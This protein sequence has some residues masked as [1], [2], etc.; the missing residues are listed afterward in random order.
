M[1]LISFTPLKYEK[2]SVLPNLRGVM[3]VSWFFL[4][5][6]VFLCVGNSQG[7]KQTTVPSLSSA[8]LNS[9]G[10][11]ANEST[12]LVSPDGT[13][14][15]G[16]YNV[17]ANGYAFAV[18]YANDSARTLAWMAYSTYLVG[19]N[20]SLMLTNGNLS[21]ID[22]NG[23]TAW[24]R[25]ISGPIPEM[26]LILQST[27]NLVLDPTTSPPAWESFTEYP[28]FNLLPTQNFTTGDNMMSRNSEGAYGGENYYSLRLATPSNQ[29]SLY[30][31]REGEAQDPD[32]YWQSPGSF[33]EINLD[34]AGFL[35][36]STMDNQIMAADRGV[37]P[38]R[39]LTLDP[40]GNLRLY[41]RNKNSPSSPWIKV[42]EAVLERC[43]IY[44]N[45]GE[46][47]ICKVDE[48]WKPECIC[49]PGF[50]PS[51]NRS[52]KEQEDG[53][54]LTF[55]AL[56]N[57]IFNGLNSNETPQA[58]PIQECMDFCM[59]NISCRGFVH[60][61]N[62]GRCVYQYGKLLNGYWSPG[63]QKRMYLK[64]AASVEK[65]PNPYSGTLSA[66][67]NV[68]KTLL[69]LPF[70]PKSSDHN[71]RDLAI[72]CSLFGAELFCGVL[73]FWAFLRKYSKFRDIARIFAMDLLP[74]GGPKKF[75]YAELKAATN[76]F[77]DI[78]GRGGFGPVYRG[79]LPDQ[80]QIAVKKLEGLLQG[81]QQF[82]AEVM[83]I[84]RIH[85]LN[86]VRMWGFCADGEHRLLV[87]EYIPNGSLDSHLFNTEGP[88]VLDW[89]IR[90]RIALGVARAIAYLHEECLEW[91]LHCDIK[92]ENILLDENFCPKV[93]DFGL[94]KLVEKER[95][96]NVSTIRGT[97]GYLAPE[98]FEVNPITA[99]ADV[100]SFGMVLLEIVSGRRNLMMPTSLA[101]ESSEWYFPD[102]AFD[103]VVMKEN[104]AEVVDKR[105]P[106][107]AENRV[108]LEAVA[109]M[110]RTALWCIQSRPEERPSMGKVA[111][112]LEGTVD[113][114]DP[115]KLN[116]LDGDTQP[117]YSG[118]MS[119]N[120]SSI[121]Y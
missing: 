10:L 15:A 82:W 52:C 99:K 23:G 77:S 71:T 11:R 116:D 113:I 80:R 25:K 118:M 31:V 89:N 13:F 42:W 33:P 4:V 34:E 41:S 97:R 88:N 21:V 17:T 26:N 92:P 69:S 119:F 76:N 55:V 28:T 2:V 22:D 115:P 102:W 112:M 100:Y 6:M 36:T 105:L 101:M 109:R 95:S 104:A 24:S 66:L 84:G 63:D 58:R 27:G 51:L 35:N 1:L 68:C 48:N 106:G 8:L 94:A 45:C 67:K 5:F 117:A 44:G 81:E 18:W 53:A 16:F 121:S 91:V 120:T 65:A 60:S 49:P 86:L 39:R 57:V 46:N 98:W 70:P 59:G 79:L 87:Y 19:A 74:S 32:P 62:N 114:Q 43:K 78:L 40:D 56:D 75:T 37:G 111:K 20:S 38:L 93:S 9:S 85:H 73:A 12:Y 72:I 14:C 83:I 96:L 29:I 107:L 110:V 61:L 64:V 90:Y 54:N 3:E 108:Q 30:Y 50:E 7:Q 103:M 47:A